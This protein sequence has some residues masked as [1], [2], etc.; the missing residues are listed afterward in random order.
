MTVELEPSDL[1]ANLGGNNHIIWEYRWLTLGDDAEKLQA[2]GAGG[3]VIGQSIADEQAT[4]RSE[5]KAA[6]YIA[7][8]FRFRSR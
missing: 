5:M 6:Q 4:L 1:Q 2:G 8:D 3:Q 7:Y